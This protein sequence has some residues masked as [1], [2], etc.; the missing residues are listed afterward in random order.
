MDYLYLTASMFT[1]LG[2]A[3]FSVEGPMRIIMAGISLLGFMTLTWSATFLYAMCSSA[4]HE[5]AEEKVNND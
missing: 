3:D 4:W 5:I 2:Y 1:T